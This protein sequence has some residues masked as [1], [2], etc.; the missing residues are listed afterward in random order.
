MIDT[1]ADVDSILG[2]EEREPSLL[3]TCI[4]CG[5]LYLVRDFEVGYRTTCTGCGSGLRD[6]SD[7]EAGALFVY[8]RD[9]EGSDDPDE[10]GY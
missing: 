2:S 5:A 6:I 7:D 3:A 9:R 1:Q 4:M 8:L 10:R